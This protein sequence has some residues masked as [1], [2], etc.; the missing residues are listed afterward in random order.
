MKKFAR[1]HTTTR[2]TH[3]NNSNVE[4]R[5]HTTTTIYILT[6]EWQ[7]EES[8]NGRWRHKQDRATTLIH[9]RSAPNPEKKS[10]YA[11][12]S[13]CDFGWSLYLVEAE[14]R[15][16]KQT[17]YSTIL[18][19]TMDSL[20]CIFFHFRLIVCYLPTANLIFRRKSVPLILSSIYL[21]KLAVG[22][23]FRHH[24]YHIV[25]EWFLDT[26]E[27]HFSFDFTPCLFFIW[28]NFFFLSLFLFLYHHYHHH[29]HRQHHHL[30]VP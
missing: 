27:F 3:T 1:K 12:D 20:M 21:Y 8:T 18:V 24:Y 10:V 22:C 4:N 25:N 9:T 2:S 15:R 6:N 26:A 13:L 23:L 7:S 11:E 17:I 19:R 30:W 14:K 5:T 29:H 28:F 16:H